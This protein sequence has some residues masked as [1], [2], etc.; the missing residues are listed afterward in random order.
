MRSR[1][2]AVKLRTSL[3]PLFLLVLAIGGCGP[4]MP[5]T[6]PVKGRIELE[7]GDIADLADSTIEIA[8]NTDPNIRSSGSIRADGTFELETLYT[9]VI[10]RGAMPGEYN[11]RL[12]LSDDGDR[13][14]KKK[15]RALVPPRYL[16]TNT[17][18]WLMQVPA[19]GEVVFK[20]AA[21]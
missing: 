5:T 7:K 8:Q 6:Y 15:R 1:L 20:V 12:V 4:A 11:A 2:A 3:L 16:S 10:L 21:K 18:G 17:S 14:A 13:E 19:G 9:G